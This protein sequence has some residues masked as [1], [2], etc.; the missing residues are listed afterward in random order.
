L[1]V[2]S[3]AAVVA[4]VVYRPLL[5]LEL[6]FLVVVMAALTERVVQELL[7]QAVVAV[8]EVVKTLLVLEEAEEL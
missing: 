6:V 1:A 2:L 8:V 3:N 7:I 4:V 5:A